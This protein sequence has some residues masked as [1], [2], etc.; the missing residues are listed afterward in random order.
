MRYLLIFILHLSFIDLPVVAVAEPVNSSRFKFVKPYR[1]IEEHQYDSAIYSLE[2]LLLILE[3]SNEKGEAYFSLGYTY[4]RIG[5]PFVAIR[6]YLKAADF[7]SEKDCISNTYEN[8]GLIYKGFNQ[9]DKAVY[10]FSRAIELEED[11]SVRMMRKLYSRSASYRRNDQTNLALDDLLQAEEIAYK[12]QSDHFRAKIYNQLG[13]LFKFRGDLSK[14]G[15]YFYQALEIAET[16]DIYHNY[17]NLKKELGDTVA[18]EQYF[19]KAIAISP[20]QKLIA[21]H[22]DLGEMY[23]YWGKPIKADLYLKEALAFYQGGG[24][25]AFNHVKLFEI[26]ALI[27]VDQQNANYYKDMAIEEYKKIGSELLKSNELF[28]GVIANEKTQNLEIKRAYKNASRDYLL[29][30]VLTGLFTTAIFIW[31]IF[32]IRRSIRERKI[33]KTFERIQN[34]IYEE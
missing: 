13:L 4:E 17:A 20:E 15:S 24:I 28:F 3:S 16:W 23:F 12:A 21:T 14:A 5:R 30:F 27:E 26:L 6:Y 31:L 18:A 29:A 34:I 7:Y 33:R 9:H 8:V 19:L 25:T 11:R 32:R 2:N 10:Y 1:Y 22:I